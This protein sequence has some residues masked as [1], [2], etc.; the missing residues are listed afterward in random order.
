[1]WEGSTFPRFRCE[2]GRSR[3]STSPQF[4]HKE[5]HIAFEGAFVAKGDGKSRGGKGGA[6]LL[7]GH[8]SISPPSCSD[9]FFSDDEGEDG[10][11]C[12]VPHPP[13]QNKEKDTFQVINFEGA[14]SQHN[15]HSDHNLTLKIQAKSVSENKNRSA[16]NLFIYGC[17]TGCSYV[18]SPLNWK[19]SSKPYPVLIYNFWISLHT[20]H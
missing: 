18:Q 12:K 3:G 16:S 6:S 1:M 13:C 19:N 14:T 5:D 15:D 20:W 8:D 4:V 11:V 17:E 7:V 2:E 10:T 9:E